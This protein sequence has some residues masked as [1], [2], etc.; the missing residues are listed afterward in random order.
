LRKSHRRDG[1]YLKGTKRKRK[2]KHKA[3]PF[4]WIIGQFNNRTGSINSIKL[5]EEPL[6]NLH[7]S[8]H[9]KMQYHN[10]DIIVKAQ[11]SL[12]V[13]VKTNI[14][15][16]NSKAPTPPKK[17]KKKKVMGRTCSVCIPEV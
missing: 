6:Q 2:G 11:K 13:S 7:N 9:L 14:Q 16:A 1:A 12:I 17:K 10:A 15:D 3:T 5:L 4:N 8:C